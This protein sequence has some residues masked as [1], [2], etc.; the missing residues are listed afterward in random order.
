MQ[1]SELGRVY[2]IDRKFNDYPVWGRQLVVSESKA[3][4]RSIT[5]KMQPIPMLDTKAELD[6]AEALEIAQA[7]I[8]DWSGTRS[9]YS[10]QR[11]IL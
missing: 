6:E 3:R 2:H 4:V 5:G 10:A 11:G 9:E 7:S 8:S 1:D